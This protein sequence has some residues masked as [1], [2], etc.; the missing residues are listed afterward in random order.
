MRQLTLTVKC[1]SS[2]AHALMYVNFY[3]DD[4]DTGTGWL[5]DPETGVIYLGPGYLTRPNLGG[6]YTYSHSGVFNSSGQVGLD[7]LVLKC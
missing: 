3:A 2:L 4:S 6:V 5:A 1:P 7:P